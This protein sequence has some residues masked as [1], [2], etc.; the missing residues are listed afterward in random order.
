METISHQHGVGVDHVDYLEAEK[1]PMGIDTMRHLLSF[2]DPDQRMNP[3]K[4]VP[5]GSKTI[6]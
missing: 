6:R 4:L 1:G 3:G 2:L 5:E